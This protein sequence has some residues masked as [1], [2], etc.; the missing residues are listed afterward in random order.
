MR[1]VF[2]AAF[3][4]VAAPAFSADCTQIVDD[5]ERL[6]CYDQESGISQVET[7]NSDSSWVV[8]TDSSDFEDTTDV[9]M[10]TESLEPISCQQF[11]TAQTAT[12]MIRC[13]E[14]TTAIFMSTSCHVASGFQGYGDVDVRV[15]DKPS[16]VA[17][18]GASTDSRALGLWRGGSSI[19]F[20][21]NQLLGGSRLL[22]RFTPFGQSPT[23][24]EFD[25]SGID[26]ALVPLR[27]ECGW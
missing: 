23:T 20:I 5:A 4:S 25:I 19:P 22:L 12:L 21:K 11:G 10:S 13:M 26:E 3:L 24:V 18:M 2:L 8:R 16:T 14:N 6:N 17:S 7:T 9:F 1:C 27:T 15:D